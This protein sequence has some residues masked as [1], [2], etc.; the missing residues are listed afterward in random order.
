MNFLLIN[1]NNK[2]VYVYLLKLLRFIIIQCKNE[3]YIELNAFLS[4]IVN[5]YHRKLIS[6]L[7]VRCFQTINTYFNAKNF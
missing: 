7:K 3:Y 5:F 2:L 4:I 1:E 6:F